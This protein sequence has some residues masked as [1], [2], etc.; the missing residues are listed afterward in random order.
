MLEIAELQWW[1]QERGYSMLNYYYDMKDFISYEAVSLALTIPGVDAWHVIFYLDDLLDSNDGALLVA[2]LEE[3]VVDSALEGMS[4]P[5]KE[6]E[7]NNSVFY[8]AVAAVY[9]QLL[10]G[11]YDKVGDLAHHALSLDYDG[12]EWE[13]NLRMLETL[14]AVM[15]GRSEDMSELAENV[16]SAVEK[17]RSD[18]KTC[19]NRAL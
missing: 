13:P 3:S 12:G 1:V 5:S 17:A 15:S 7:Y 19:L 9:R 14:D 2:S 10:D 4:Q 18:Y 11:D 8:A 16:R 6:S